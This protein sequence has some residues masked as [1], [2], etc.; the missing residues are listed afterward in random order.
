LLSKELATIHLQV[1][2]Q[3]NIEDF[4]LKEYDKT[5]LAK[6]LDEL[7]FKTLKTKLIGLTEE[8]KQQQKSA[9][10]QAAT[11]QLDLFGATTQGEKSNPNAEKT[12]VIPTELQNIRTKL[13]HYH[14][15]DTPLLRQK[16]IEFLHLQKAFCF[17]TETTSL[18]HLQAELVGIFFCLLSQ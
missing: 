3:Y 14:I 5:A 10:K 4:R 2:I 6:I 7:E 13:H 12:E 15:V 8:E 9:K 11:P 18:D 16:L 1:P 17:D